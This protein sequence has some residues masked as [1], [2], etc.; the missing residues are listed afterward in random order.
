M[1]QE[2]AEI[3]VKIKN[4][5]YTPIAFVIQTKVEFHDAFKNI[6]QKIYESI[7][8]PKEYP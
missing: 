2:K 8:D 5:Y 1:H 3:N 6:L 7:K 4:L